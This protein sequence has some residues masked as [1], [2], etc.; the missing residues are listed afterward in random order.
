[1]GPLKEKVPICGLQARAQP[2][3]C[4]LRSAMEGQGD[5]AG[6]KQTTNPAWSSQVRGGTLGRTSALSMRITPYETHEYTQ[7][8]NLF[9]RGPHI[10]TPGRQDITWGP[11]G[12]LASA[13][14]PIRSHAPLRSTMG[15]LTKGYVG[16]KLLGG[17][18]TIV[19]FIVT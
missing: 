6:E 11:L 1:M 17:R 15:P 4:P 2:H 18:F 12:P 19:L 9:P 8:A 10:G 16:E 13:Q 3:A 5:V 7:G 14:A